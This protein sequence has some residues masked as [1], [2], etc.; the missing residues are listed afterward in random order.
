MIRQFGVLT[1]DSR[2]SF[3]SNL[4]LKN[5]DI[6]GTFVPG[7]S[8]LHGLACLS[9]YEIWTIGSDNNLTFDY[10]KYMK[11][12]SDKGELLQSIKSDH[13]PVAIA[14]TKSYDLVYA[15]DYRNVNIIE[16]NQIKKVIKLKEWKAL[17]ICSTLSGDLLVIMND[18]KNS[19][20]VVRYFGSTE[21]QT[22]QFNDDGQSLYSPGEKKCLIENRNLDICVADLDAHAVVAV[23]QD[24]K[25][26]YRYTGQTASERSFDPNGIATDSQSRVLIATDKNHYIHVLDQEGQFLSLIYMHVYSTK[27]FCV[28]AN[29]SLFVADFHKIY[30]IK[31]CT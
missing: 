22:I 16:V 19:S 11:L 17:D 8:W 1:T 7:H 5:S 20:K 3:Q 9:E 23:N 25:L 27:G 6:I 12:Y 13:K 18:G 30:K 26:R 10:D 15:D 4:L 31:Y 29:D 24:G 2:C 14:V 21:K 28:D